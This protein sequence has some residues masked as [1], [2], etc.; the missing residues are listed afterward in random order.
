MRALLELI[1]DREQA[2]E[3]AGDSAAVARRLKDQEDEAELHG[4]H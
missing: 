3:L 4:R 1:I 2:E